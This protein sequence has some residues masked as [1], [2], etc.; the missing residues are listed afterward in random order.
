MTDESELEVSGWLLTDAQVRLRN[1][2]T[3]KETHDR[4]GHLHDLPLW[5][6]KFDKCADNVRNEF[7]GTPGFFRYKEFRPTHYFTIPQRK[8]TKINIVCQNIF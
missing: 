4:L 6:D 1:G 7:L 2:T 8:V 5:Q 3:V